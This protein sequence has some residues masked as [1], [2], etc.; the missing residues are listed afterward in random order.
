MNE[1]DQDCQIR[2]WD[3]LV[4]HTIKAVVVSPTGPRDVAAVIVT[5]TGCWMAIDAENGSHDE[6]P[7]VFV[8][9][10]YFGSDD[11]PLDQYL[12]AADCWNAGLI[13]QATYEL[14]KAKEDA[15]K[16]EA[17]KRKAEFLRRQLAELEG[18]AA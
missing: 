8:S 16:A 13:N 2:D 5:E 11:V 9:P 17:K 6:A 10:P 12:S 7:S 14:L 3:E 18:G 15:K 1:L 4:G